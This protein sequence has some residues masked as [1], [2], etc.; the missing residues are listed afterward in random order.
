[1]LLGTSVLA[2]LIPAR[3]AAALDPLVALRHE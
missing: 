3:Q 2:C 1:V